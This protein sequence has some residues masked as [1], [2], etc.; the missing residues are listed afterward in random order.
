MESSGAQK[1]DMTEQGKS[2]HPLSGEEAKRP[3]PPATEAPVV[4]LF[5]P[6][7]N[8]TYEMYL[9]KTTDIP[10]QLLEAKFLSSNLFEKVTLASFARSGNTLIRK[11]LEDITGTVTGSDLVIPFNFFQSLKEFGV[12]GEETVDERTWIVKSHSPSQSS[13]LK[14]NANKCVLLVRNPTDA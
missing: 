5:E 1:E 10:E 12:K 7:Q 4:S 6:D 14:F 11:Y 2:T 13:P 9:Q 3:S 8:P